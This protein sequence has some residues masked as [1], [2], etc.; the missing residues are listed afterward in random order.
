MEDYQKEYSDFVKE[1]SSR[2]VDGK[3][4]GILVSKFSAWFGVYNLAMI[5][6]LKAYS[7]V[8]RD[9]S[10]E[11]DVNGKAISSARAEQ[12]AAA[13][14][15]AYEYEKARAHVQNLESH[16]AALKGMQRA[17]MSEYTNTY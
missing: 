7:A 5:E 13:T 17:V 14:P 12:L 1:I 10:Y 9:I 3:E 15:E 8:T 2:E 6:A 16:I 4:V 11:T